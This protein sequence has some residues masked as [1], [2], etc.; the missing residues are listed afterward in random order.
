MPKKRSANASTIHIPTLTS[1]SKKGIRRTKE[2]S[3]PIPHTL[4]IMFLFFL[5]GVNSPAPL[6]NRK[7]EL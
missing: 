7:N 2:A 3:M 6:V 1:K 5:F 4:K